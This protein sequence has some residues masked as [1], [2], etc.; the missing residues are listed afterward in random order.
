MDT[1]NISRDKINYTKKSFP[2]LQGIRRDKYLLIMLIPGLTFFIIFK[3]L[4]MGGLLIAF[5]DYSIFKGIWESP[6]VGLTHFRKVFNSP[7][8]WNVLRNTLLISS[9]KLIFGFPAPIILSLLLNEIRSNSFKR[10]VQTVIYLPHFI[11]WV[12]IA[13]IMRSILSPTYGILGEVYKLFNMQPINLMASLQHFRSLLVISDIWKEMG[14]GTII[15]LASLST[16]D[17]NLFEAAIIDGASKLKQVFYITLPSIKSVII[18]LLILKIGGLMNAGFEQ[19][20]VMQNDLVR[21]IS[22]IFDT[23]VYR[24]GIQK[25]DYSFSAAVGMFNSVVSLILIFSANKFA[26]LIGEEGIL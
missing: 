19:I 14:W 16:I 21:P 7:D 8:F 23:F 6:W 13:G 20:Y 9:Y 2:L 11:S 10:T 15:Y 25:A 5:K 24:R 1:Q 22:D 4:P 12:I 18:L 17:P 3:Y 26:K